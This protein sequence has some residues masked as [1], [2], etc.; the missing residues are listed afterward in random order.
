MALKSYKDLK[1]WQT[2]M[3]LNGEVYKLAKSL[4]ESEIEIS[5]QIRESAMYVAARI[6]EAQES[7]DVSADECFECLSSAHSHLMEVEMQLQIGLIIG[8]FK[9]SDTKTALN[10][11]REIGTVLVSMMEELEDDD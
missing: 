3:A 2:S 5:K 8:Y 6:A 11:C 9:D 10:F 1:V 7:Y 4:P